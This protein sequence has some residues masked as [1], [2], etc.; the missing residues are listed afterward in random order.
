MRGRWPLAAPALALLLVLLVWPLGRLLAENLTAGGA[1]RV[2]GSA[3]L[4]GRVGWTL[5]QA[6]VTTLAAVA[7]GV[8]A[9]AVLARARFPGKAIVE[10]LLTLPLVVPTVVAGVGFLALLGPRGLL[11][12]DLSRGPWLVLLANLFYN[13]PL[14]VRV[15]GVALASAGTAAEEA[16]R[17]LGSGPARAFARATLP[18]VRPA[19]LASGALVFLYSAGSFGVPLLLGGPA[20]ATVEVEVYGLVAFRLRLEEAAALA[21]VQGLVT[22]AAAGLYARWAALGTPAL[23]FADASRPPATFAARAAVTLV[24]LG[25]LA[26][27]LSPVLA[28]VARSLWGPEGLTLAWYAALADGAGSLLSLPAGLA[29]RNTFVLAVA[30]LA[31]C[32]PTGVGMAAAIARSRGG[33]LD[34]LSLAPLAVSAVSL[35]VGLLLAY[36]GWTASPGLLVGAYALVSLPL[37]VRSVAP[38]LRAVP[39]RALEAARTLGSTPAR[40]WRRV[41]WPLA[42]PAVRAGTALAFA[43]TVGEF[44]ATLV[45]GRPEW[46][47]LAVAVLDRLGRPGRQGEAAALSTVLLAFALA[48]LLLAGRARG[49]LG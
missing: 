8:P 16:A 17:T 13:L 33:V 21:A 19:V 26:L 27:A 6:L 46:A 9:A 22:L 11:G 48:G 20:Y 49:R 34:A 24:V 41:A 14:V 38:A 29:A 31:V 35:G 1:A 12:L 39:P 3:Y 10:A 37:V 42:R 7:L 5:A 43:A 25:L 28:V 15:L 44:G 45:L 40:A 30:T 47:T 4:R 2:L 36:P 23:A 18:L 32:V